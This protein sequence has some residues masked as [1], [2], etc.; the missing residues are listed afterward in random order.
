MI[1]VQ[2]QPDPRKRFA[3]PVYVAVTRA[4][5]RC[6]TTLVAIALDAATAGWC[7]AP[8][9]L[10]DNASELRP[11][12]LG[13]T[14]VPIVDTPIARR[15]PELAVLSLLAHRGEASALQI[16]RAVLAACDDL[17]PER[18]ELYADIVIGFINEAARRVLEAEMNLEN[19]E[20]QSE[21]LRKLKASAQAQGEAQGH[22]QG[23]AEGRREALTCAVVEVLAARGLAVTDEQRARITA[24]TDPDALVAWL[25]RAATASNADELFGR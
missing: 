2:L 11:L 6:P 4:R 7:A 20:V 21:F 15:H 5:L 12:V 13:P 10:D 14:R 8:I 24:C 19:Y 3:W 1:E 18:A 22:A 23:Q 16:G 17:D 25:Q 9:P